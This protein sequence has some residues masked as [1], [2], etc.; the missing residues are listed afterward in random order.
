MET[1][2]TSPKFSADVRERAVLMAFE[3]RTEHASQ[4]ASI[5]TIG[6]KIGCTTD[7]INQPINGLDL[8]GRLP[9]YSL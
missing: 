2:K 7:I 3:H 8:S 6:A 9:E 4:W 1:H 5:V